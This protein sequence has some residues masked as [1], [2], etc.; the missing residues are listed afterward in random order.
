MLKPVLSADSHVLEIPEV[1]SKRIDSKFKDRAPYL[2]KNERHGAMFVIPGINFR[3]PMALL[4]GAGRAPD[5][6]DEKADFEQLQ[7]GGWD[8]KKRIE[9]Q[10][11]DSIAAEILYP[12]IGMV[13]CK[14]PDHDYRKACLDAYNL[15]LAEYCS[16]DRNRLLGIGM[17]S[18]RTPEDSIAEARQI[19]KLGLRGVMLPGWPAAEDYDSRMY[20]PFWAACVDL[21]LPVTFHHLP[22]ARNPNEPSDSPYAPQARGVNSKLSS[23]MNLIRGNQDLLAMFV[24]GG[25]FERHP[26]LKLICAEADAGWIPHFMYRMDYAYDHHRHHMKTELLS[27]APSDYFR[28]NVYIS[29][30]DDYVA[31]QIRNLMNIR[32][33]MWAND[34]PHFDSTWPHSKEVIAK[35]TADMTEQEK[36]WI[37][38]DN[39]AECYG[40]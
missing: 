4:S 33:L 26:R 36:N 7:S 3:L 21:N 12:S 17:V 34:F 15:W 35:H 30:Q 16:L 40:L 32:R 2:E 37:L 22:G 28:N 6:M 23:W 20:D 24:F 1:W 19:K 31:F 39:L 27:K 9:D 11:R 29:F 38:H 18:M 8:P 13:L 5:K 10:N 25:V 14:H